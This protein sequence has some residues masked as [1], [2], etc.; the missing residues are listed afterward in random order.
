LYLSSRDRLIEKLKKKLSDASDET[1]VK[2]VISNGGYKKFTNIKEG[3][4]ITL[5][6]KAIEEDA[7]WDGF[8]GIA[9][10]NNAKLTVEQALSRYRD[11]YHVEEAFRVVKCTLKTRP[12]F[13]WAPHRIRT[14]ILLCFMNLFLERFLEL[15][16]RREETPLTPDRIRYAL[17][18]IHTMIF[19]ESGTQKVSEMRSSLSEEATVILN[20]LKISTDRSAQLCQV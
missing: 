3:S 8:H 20:T 10:S 5:N 14:H 16:L 1:S 19:E 11:L 6:E 4:L 12:I 18:G 17:S 13:H 9:V 2:K 15:L 7:K